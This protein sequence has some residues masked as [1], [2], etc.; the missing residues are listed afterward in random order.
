MDY[1]IRAGLRPPRPPW[2]LTPQR[3]DWLFMAASLRITAEVT[4]AA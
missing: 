1:A 2:P 3:L 4:I